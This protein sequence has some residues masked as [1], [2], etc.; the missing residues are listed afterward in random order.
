MARS[1][2][3]LTASPLIDAWSTV[4]TRRRGLRRLLRH[5]L[6]LAGLFI[7]GGLTLLALAAPHLRLRDPNQQL[8]NGLDATGMPRLPGQAGTLL[9]TDQVG[10]D[11]FSRLVFGARISL[12]VGIVAMLTAVIIGVTI[13]LLA[14]YW[15]GLVDVLLMRFTDVMMTFPSLLLAIAFAGLMDGRKVHLHPAFLHWHRL[16]VRLER[17]LVSLFFVIGIVSWTGI[18]RVVR[19]QTLSLK[20]RE[21]VEAARAIGCS[22]A[23]IILRHLLPNILPVI[24]VLATMSTA[25]T[26]LLDA[27]LSY[28]GVGIPPPTPSWGKMI[29]DGQPYLVTAPLLVMAPGLCVVLAVVGFNLLGQGLQD[30]LDPYQKGRP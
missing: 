5:H 28:L 14:G 6:V 27:G 1:H 20:E 10:R 19:A 11:V 12:L 29:V 26:I 7:V 25:G 9:G 16:D 13:G 2:R 4:T 30:A 24:I 21:F 3:R 23:R 17:G 18:A 8:Q 15:G 22:H